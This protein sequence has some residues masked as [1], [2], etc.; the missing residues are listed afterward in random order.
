MTHALVYIVDRER[1]ARLAGGGAWSRPRRC[2]VCRRREASLAPGATPTAV[3]D[4]PPA[5]TGAFVETR[6]STLRSRSSQPSIK[7]ISTPDAH[8]PCLV[9]GHRR[10][11]TTLASFDVLP[12]D[13]PACGRL[14]ALA[15]ASRRDLPCQFR[16][17]AARF[18]LSTTARLT[19]R[20]RK[21]RGDMPATGA[22]RS[23]AGRA[24]PA[25]RH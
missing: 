10:V 1:A 21:T 12:A 19:A 9:E 15:R 17:A 8:V 20:L 18:V 24:C 13:A 3:T 22:F 6:I 4:R 5:Q 2:P 23:S 25:R 11:G 16:A 14:D 7:A